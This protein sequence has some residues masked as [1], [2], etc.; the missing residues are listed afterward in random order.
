MLERASG[1]LWA[2]SFETQTPFATAWGNEGECWMLLGTSQPLGVRANQNQCLN[3]FGNR[4]ATTSDIET[5]CNR[6]G[7]NTNA[8]VRF[9]NLW[10]T[11][12]DIQTPSAAAGGIKVNVGMR[13][14]TSGPP[15]P[16]LRLPPQ[17]LGESKPML[18]CALGTSGPTSEIQTPLATAW[19]IKA[20]VGMCFGNL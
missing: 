6:L 11:N 13:F 1:N 4:W 14:G 8:G 20:N 18:E 9:G 16:I 5:P 3:A 12:S 15:T 2:T 19:G 17:P 10:A 7:I